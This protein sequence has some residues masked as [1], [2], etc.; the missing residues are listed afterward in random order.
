MPED[1]DPRGLRFAL[2]GAAASGFETA[3]TI[4]D[5]DGDV[6]ISAL[7]VPTESAVCLEDVVTDNTIEVVLLARENLGGHY[8]AG[9][10]VIPPNRP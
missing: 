10:G 7:L 9:P 5:F 6:G 3:P 2:L 1:F 4:A 8:G